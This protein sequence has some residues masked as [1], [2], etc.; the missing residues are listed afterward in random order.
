MIPKRSCKGTILHRYLMTAATATGEEPFLQGMIVHDDDTG[1]IV[2]AY[3]D[4]Y[5]NQ[6]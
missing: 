6:L 2:L 3:D 4:Y 5:N 1:D